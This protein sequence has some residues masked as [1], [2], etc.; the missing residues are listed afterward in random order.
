MNPNKKKHAF[1]SIN[2]I[3]IW[4]ESLYKVYNI[5]NIRH[6]LNTKVATFPF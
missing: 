1:N 4:C 2:L 3:E 5:Q 6:S